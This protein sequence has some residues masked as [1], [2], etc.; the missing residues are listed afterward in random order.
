MTADRKQDKKMNPGH[1]AIAASLVWF[2][3]ISIRMLVHG[4]RHLA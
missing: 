3:A 4:F 1:L 2:L